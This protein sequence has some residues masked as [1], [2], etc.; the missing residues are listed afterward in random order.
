MKDASVN[1]QTYLQDKDNFELEYNIDDSN[2]Q[3][4]IK[5][6]ALGTKAFFEYTPTEDSIKKKNRKN[7]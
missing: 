6:V 3:E 1:Y 7:T 5:T 4:L 2:W